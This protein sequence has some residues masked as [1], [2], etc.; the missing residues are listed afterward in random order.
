MTRRL[1]I[2]CLGC[3]L[4]APGQQAAPP[5]DVVLRALADELERSRELRVVSLEKPYYI[6]YAIHETDTFSVSATLGALNAAQAG[7]VRLPRVQVRVGDYAYDNGNYVL[8]DYAFTSRYDLGACPI[9]DDYSAIRQYFWL[10]TDTAYKSALEAFA[11]KRASQKNVTVADQLPDF[12]KVE[13]VTMS[14]PAARRKVDDE[15]WKSRVR[16]LSALF[17]SREGII[18]SSVEYYAGQGYYYLVT[19]EGTRLKIPEVSQHLQARASALAPDG[20]TLRDA[21]GFHALDADS[22][23]TEGELRRG[24]EGMIGNLGALLRAP[25]AEPYTGPV[26][27]EPAAAAQLMAEVL[28]RSFA[29]RRRPVS[30]PGRSMPF[31]ASELEGRLGSRILPEWMDVVDDPAAADWRGQRLL[32][33]YDVDLEGVVPKP[34]TLVEKGLLRNYLS[35]RQPV[36]GAL[37]SNGR[38]RLLGSFGAKGAS[39]GNLFV[40]A[41]ATTTLDELKKKLV[42]IAGQRDKPFGLLIRKMDFPSSASVPEAQRL[43]SAVA[44]D[45]TSARAV[46]LPV[47]V[48]RVFPDGREELVRGLRFKD[49]TLR[50]LRDILAAG[51]EPGVLNYLENG[52]PFALLGAASYVAESSV[53]S[54]GLLFEELQLV[55]AQE[56]MPRLPIVPPPVT[57]AR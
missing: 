31:V 5:S 18:G 10:A 3:R 34:L 22:L 7:R 42:E 14:V 16:A 20:M 48:Y 23:P 37:E 36:K 21:L 33:Q 9:D 28:G 26:L 30:E 11:R 12:S 43:L 32:G 52:A 57:P 51:G 4:L 35:T 49:L 41:S 25:V 44:Q 17:A 2:A 27:F 19:S 13:P 56:E 15:G 8:S 45:G 55:K 39:F 1:L 46:S 6:E 29:L 47:L 54:P 40:R 53:V 50:S 24:I 38:A